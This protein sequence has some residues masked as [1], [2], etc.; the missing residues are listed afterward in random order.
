M[1]LKDSNAAIHHHCWT[2]NVLSQSNVRLLVILLIWLLQTIFL[3]FWGPIYKNP[4]SN[5]S[6][7]E[8]P[9]SC[10]TTQ[11]GIQH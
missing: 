5:L 3:L 1:F 4:K 10:I 2:S 8:T 11:L 7:A 9:A 6:S